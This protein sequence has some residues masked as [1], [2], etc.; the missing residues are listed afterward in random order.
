MQGSEVEARL[1][2]QGY[3]AHLKGILARYLPAAEVY[4]PLAD[5][6]GSLDYA[7]D[8]GRRVF[9]EHNAMCREIDVVLAYLPSA[10]M[11]TA[12]EMWQAHQAGRAVITISQ[13]EHNWVVRF[14]SDA[15]YPD[16][17]AFEAAARSGQFAAQIESILAD[18]A[19]D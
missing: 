1:F 12:I 4:D 6:A 8:D 19:A 17:D 5:H 7:P 16:L 18:R 2:P 10:S 11:G 3:R 13:L 9:L 14:L 15:V